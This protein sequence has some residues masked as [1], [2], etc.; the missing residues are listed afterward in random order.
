MSEKKGSFTVNYDDLTISV[1]GNSEQF[2]GLDLQ[3]KAIQALIEMMDF[4]FAEEEDP[5]AQ[6]KVFLSLIDT[7]GAMMKLDFHGFDDEKM[8]IE[9]VKD[10]IEWTIANKLHKQ[11]EYAQLLDQVNQEDD[12]WF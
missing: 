2:G 11:P 9:F 4:K 5:E 10:F 6:Q 8:N 1:E 3:V 12:S 7:I